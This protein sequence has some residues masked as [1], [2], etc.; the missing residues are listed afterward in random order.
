MSEQLTED[1]RA[2]FALILHD[3]D[4]LDAVAAV[5]RREARRDPEWFGALLRRALRVGHL[6]P[7]R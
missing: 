5:L 4:Q 3:P 1:E 6:S 2:R 7:Y